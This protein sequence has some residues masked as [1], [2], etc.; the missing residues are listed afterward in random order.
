MLYE[1]AS[2][3]ILISER[4]FVQRT[5]EMDDFY[6]LLFLFCSVIF[7]LSFPVI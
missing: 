5:L 6:E 2:F 3:V 1:I 4:R 7:L